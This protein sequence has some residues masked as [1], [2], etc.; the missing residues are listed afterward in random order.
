MSKQ[1]DIS[2][3]FVH[4]SKAYSIILSNT[5]DENKSHVSFLFQFLRKKGRN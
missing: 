3:Y 1:F 5:I 2:I 4:V